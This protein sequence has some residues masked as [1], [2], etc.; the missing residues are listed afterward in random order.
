MKEKIV[1][2]LNNHIDS[3][4]EKPELTNEEYMILK[5]KL[6]EIK[7]AEEEAARKIDWEQ[8]MKE[9]TTLMFSLPGGGGMCVQ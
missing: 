8:K 4:L 9:L 7:Y 6:R 1:A 3:L 5:E 2:K